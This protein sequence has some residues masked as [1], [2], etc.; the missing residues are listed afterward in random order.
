[1][2]PHNNPGVERRFIISLIVTSVILVAEIA[3]GLWTGSLALLS[4]AA[5]VFMDSFALVLSYVALRLSALPADDRHTYGFHRLEVIAALINGISLG[6]IAIGI[7]FEAYE[8]LAAPQPVRSLEMMII[9]AI[10]LVANLVVAFVLGGHTHVDDHEHEHAHEDEHEHEQAHARGKVQDLN[11][12][13]AFLHV[14]GDAV[15]S[16]GVIIAGLIIWRTGWQWVD[17]VV[18]VLIGAL[19]VVSAV[20]VLRSSLHILVEGVPEGMSIKHIG[21]TMQAVPAVSEVHDLHVWSICS[22]RVALSSH[23]VLEQQ[24]GRRPSEVL[25]ELKSK[26]SGQFGIEHTTIQFEDDCD[27][28]QR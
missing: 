15:S 18:S 13:S 23:V 9:A 8:R 27:C 20:R 25:A 11:V 1:M 14:I 21:E 6:A 17:P 26:L 4:D 10:G 28:P 22:G 19:I 12:H 16:V 3:G 7:W 5:H 2:N 24:S